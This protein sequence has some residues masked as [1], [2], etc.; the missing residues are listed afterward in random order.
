MLSVSN[1]QPL[2]ETLC[3]P[4]KYVVRRAREQICRQECGQDDDPNDGEKAEFKCHHAVCLCNIPYGRKYAQFNG[5]DD[6]VMYQ[7]HGERGAWRVS[8]IHARMPSEW[9]SPEV[10]VSMSSHGKHFD[11]HFNEHEMKVEK[12]ESH[13]GRIKSLLNEREV[14]IQSWKK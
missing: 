9:I 6:D 13:N 10:E 3:K 1:C 14:N 5:I 4:H 12:L 8:R 11:E 7:V 2:F